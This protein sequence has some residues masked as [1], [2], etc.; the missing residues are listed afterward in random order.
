ML[1]AHPLI[2][3]AAPEATPP[4]TTQNA[5]PAKEGVA[6]EFGSTSIHPN[7]SK[8]LDLTSPVSVG[9]VAATLTVP[10]NGTVNVLKPAQN[11]VNS[12]EKSA[13]AEVVRASEAEPKAPW[14]TLF[15][16]NRFTTN[17]MSLSYI[18][19][20][21][22]DGQPMVQLDK[23]E[24]EAEENKWRCA[25][26]AYILGD[27]PGFQTIED[28]HEI[29]CVGPYYI[30]N[31]PIILKQW[32]PDFDFNE[33]FPTVIPL[34]VKFPKLPMSCWEVGPL[35]RIASVI[36]KPIF[37][38][39]CTT[40]K[41]RLPTEVMVMDPTGKKF[42]QVVT[43][44]RK[45]AYYDKCLVVGHKYSNQTRPMM[46]Q[47]MQPKK[48]RSN[49]DDKGKAVQSHELNLINFPHL[50]PILVRNRFKAVSISRYEV[51][52]PLGDSDGSSNQ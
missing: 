43:Y 22:V 27:G 47:P 19:P 2:E 41:T 23:S 32:T 44:D 18:P 7:I 39:E 28:A 26:I 24:V 35:S 33:E 49:K 8:R 10:A 42:M 21:I 50:S 38:D 20:Q 3:K 14:A 30:A 40:K 1:S 45:P 51:H 34:W 12:S 48:V 37:A 17:G 31:K 13:E 52:I 16:K 6:C 9:S 15:Q 25:L 46:Q 29:L 11:Q 5:D 36:G 4:S